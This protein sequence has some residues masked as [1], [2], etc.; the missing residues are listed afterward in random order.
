M[1]ITSYGYP[2]QIDSV[3]WARLTEELGAAYGVQDAADWKVTVVAGPDRTV[4][5]AAGTGWGRGILDVNSAAVNLQHATVASGVRY[6]TIMA[7]R[8]WSTPATTFTIV[9]GTSTAAVSASRQVGPG[10]VDDQPLALVQITAGST[11]PVIVADLRT[12]TSK[13]LTVN[14]LRALVDPRLG[15]EAVLSTTNVRYRRVLDTGGS[16]IWSPQSPMIWTAV[17]SG[18]YDDWAQGTWGSMASV[19]L[20][21]SAPPG[22]YAISG[23][24]AANYTSGISGVLNYQITAAGGAPAGTPQFAVGPIIF[25][26]SIPSFVW[27][28]GGGAT[29]VS[30]DVIAWSANG[31]V[32]Q[33]GTWITVE[34]KGP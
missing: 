29:T 14:D 23:S 1:A 13:V 17:R 10:T 30:L 20:P 3:Q 33:Q 16:P 21:S 7:H 11:V 22:R 27:T 18:N 2:N 4:A 31:R 25:P 9:Q 5:V 34:Y 15:D 8:N 12:W 32:Y 26:V 6:D 19:S 28:W 24:I